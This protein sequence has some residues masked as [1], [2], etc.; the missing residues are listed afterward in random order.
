MNA[1]DDLSL[2]LPGSSFVEGSTIDATL[3]GTPA[4][5]VV[6]ADGRL[7]LVRSTTW[8][9]TTRNPYATLAGPG[10]APGPDDADPGLLADLGAARGGRPAAAPARGVGGWPPWPGRRC[11]SGRRPGCYWRSPAGSASW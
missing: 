1:L 11:R 9:Y 3:R 7:E 5:D 2:E 6:A 8:G 4:G 10:A